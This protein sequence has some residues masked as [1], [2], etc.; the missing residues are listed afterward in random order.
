MKTVATELEIL[1]IKNEMELLK[2]LPVELWRIVDEFSDAKTHT[3]LRA[4]CS[5]M[6]DWIPYEK[7]V[8]FIG[9]EKLWED[10]KLNGRHNKP[11]FTEAFQAAVQLDSQTITQEHYEYLCNQN[12]RFEVFRICKLA[13]LSPFTCSHIDISSCK[14]FAIRRASSNGRAAIVQLLLADSR[15]NPAA[16]DNFAIKYASQNGY[17]SVVHLLLAD[18]RLSS[19]V[20]DNNLIESAI[21]SASENGHS[22]VV[23]ML[24]QRYQAKKEEQ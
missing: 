6:R 15:V 16:D 2:L 13:L 23:E 7:K 18:S 4:S 5:S 24:Q 22:K 8:E 19:A 10:F 12:L 9:Y 21:R 20:L 11:R 1:K 3:R 17:L 14:D